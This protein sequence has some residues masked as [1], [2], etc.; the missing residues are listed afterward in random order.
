M[1]TPP[2]NDA[3]GL[4]ERNRETLIAIF[5]QFTEI[6]SVIVFGSRAKGT[7]HAGSD[8]DLAIVGSGVTEKTLAALREA[9][10]ESDL[11]YFVD[12]IHLDALKNSSLRQHIERV[13]KEL[14]S[15]QPLP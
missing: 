15:K 6:E 9:L 4:T 7:Y 2:L 8:I 12:V 5:L 11:P 3:F 13:G 14:Y 1:N 10:E